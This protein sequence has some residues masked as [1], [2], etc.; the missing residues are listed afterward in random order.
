MSWT[1]GPRYIGTWLY[2]HTTT[3]PGVYCTSIL[4]FDRR[5]LQRFLWRVSNIY[6][7][8][9]IYIYIWPIKRSWIVM[10]NYDYDQF[11]SIYSLIVFEEF[12]EL[13]GML[14]YVSDVNL[15][16]VIFH[17]YVHIQLSATNQSLLRWKA[18]QDVVRGLHKCSFRKPMGHSLAYTWR[19]SFCLF[20]R[21]CPMLDLWWTRNG[22]K[23]WLPIIDFNTDHWVHIR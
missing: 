11:L 10:F 1:I 13:M 17:I 8:I 23:F 19:T 15:H 7:Y 22:C 12:E 9:Y 20:G 4:S 21:I 2:V 14:F 16:K 5:P 3:F 6:I 18:I